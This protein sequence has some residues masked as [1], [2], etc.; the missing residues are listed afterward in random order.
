[1]RSDTVK[2]PKDGASKH[3]C[4]PYIYHTNPASHL[5]NDP[6]SLYMKTY[7]RQVTLF[8]KEPKRVFEHR[9][10]LYIT[11]PRQNKIKSISSYSSHMAHGP[12]CNE[13]STHRIVQRE[14]LDT[15]CPPNFTLPLRRVRHAMQP[16]RVIIHS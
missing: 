14:L 15:L 8:R 9:I 11:H 2:D 10:I 3:S 6:R 1:M 5:S 7:L 13:K 16:P 12:K 4:T